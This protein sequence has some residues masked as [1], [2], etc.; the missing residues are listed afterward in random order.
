M[1]EQETDHINTQWFLMHTN[2]EEAF[3]RN[4]NV[5]MF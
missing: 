4:I 2:V 5:S 1:W 3:I